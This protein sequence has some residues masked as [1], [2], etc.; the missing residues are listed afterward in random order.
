MTTDLYERIVSR[1]GTLASIGSKIPGYRGYQEAQV[2]RE[3]DRLIRDYVARQFQQQLDRL[4]DIENTLLERGGL[5]WM[6]NTRN[7]KTQMT[8]FIERI[9][10]AARGYSGLFTNIK[11]DS[12]EL[13]KL[14]AFDEA[15]LRY[16]EQ[17]VAAFDRLQQAASA[18]EGIGD[19]LDALR[20]LVREAD[21]AFALRKDVILGLSDEIGSVPGPGF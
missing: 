17:F 16:E 12:E 20:A 10:T 21:Q 9:Q 1:R 7:L 18:N 19:A 4:L 3:A 6:S 14:Y 13:E 8:T 15:M 5:E 2:R 11:I